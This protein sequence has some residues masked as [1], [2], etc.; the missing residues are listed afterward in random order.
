MNLNCGPLLAV[1]VFLLLGLL[2]EPLNPLVTSTRQIKRECQQRFMSSL[3]R[4][5]Q[6]NLHSKDDSLTG[7]DTHHARRDTLV[8]R[9]RTFLLE[10]LRRDGRDAGPRCLAFERGGALNARSAVRWWNRDSSQQSW[11]RGN[12]G[13]ECCRSAT[14]LIVSMGAFVKGPIAPEMRP[15]NDVWIAGRPPSGY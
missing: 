15:I 12:K 11:Y 6:A 10:H 3:G 4:G 7:G 1:L 2:N 13:R 5:R 8:E 9:F 14:H